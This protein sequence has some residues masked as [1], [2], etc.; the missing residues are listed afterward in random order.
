MK[1]STVLRVVGKAENTG[2]HVLE[3]VGNFEP[4]KNDHLVYNKQCYI[5]LYVEYDFDS[6]VMYIVVKEN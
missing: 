1:K 6:S 5:V 3:N 2:F 4:R